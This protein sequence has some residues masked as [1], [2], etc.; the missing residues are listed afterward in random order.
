[1][2]SVICSIKHMGTEGSSF[3]EMTSCRPLGETVGALVVVGQQLDL[4]TLPQH[5]EPRLRVDVVSGEWP[6]CR[7]GYG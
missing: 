6:R 4:G 2:T 7:S 3:S 1:M 5:H